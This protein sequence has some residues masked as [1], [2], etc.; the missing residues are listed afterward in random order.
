MLYDQCEFKIF[1]LFSKSLVKTPY[2]MITLTSYIIFSVI[3]HCRCI[4]KMHSHTSVS[5]PQVF[6]CKQNFKL[7]PQKVKLPYRFT[8]KW[9]FFFLR[10]KG[11]IYEFA[12]CKT[13]AR[14]IKNN[15]VLFIIIICLLRTF[16]ARIHFLIHSV[17]CKI[18]WSLNESLSYFI[19]FHDTLPSF[20]SAKLSEKYLDIKH[21]HSL[22]LTFNYLS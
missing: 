6:C 13:K 2:Q 21:W 5:K 14:V 16:Q 9:I 7:L 18:D 11:E 3:H 8:F 1:M 12:L 19:L 17:T 10:I 22:S 15:L 20:R 4:L